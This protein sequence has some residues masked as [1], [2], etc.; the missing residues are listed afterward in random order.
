MHL[1][2]LNISMR[3]SP[4]TLGLEGRSTTP[5]ARSFSIGLMTFAPVRDR[6][7]RSVSSNGELA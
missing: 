4:A 3:S 6:F 1:W 5:S 7:P 2:D